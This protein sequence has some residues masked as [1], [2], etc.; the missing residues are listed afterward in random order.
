MALRDADDGWEREGLSK[1]R[2]EDQTVMP[3]GANSR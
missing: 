2:Q 1:V 3:G